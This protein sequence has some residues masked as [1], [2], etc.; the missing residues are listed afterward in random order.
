MR[1]MT[2]EKQVLNIFFIDAKNN[3][4]FQL[5]MLRLLCWVKITFF[6]KNHIDT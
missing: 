3:I 4:F 5:C 2:I 1:W 6:I